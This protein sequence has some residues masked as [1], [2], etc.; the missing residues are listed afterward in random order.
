M[1]DAAAC[2]LAVNAPWLVT[3]RYLALSGFPWMLLCLAALCAADALPA[4]MRQ[5]GVAWHQVASL[6]LC[7]DVL[8]TACHRAAHTWLRGTVVG[9]S[10]A[11]HHTHVRPTPQDAFH[12]GLV[13]ATFQ[14][15][16][17]LVAA[18]HL[19]QP[20]RHSAIA[21]G[22][23]YSWW[24]LFLHSSPDVDYPRLRRLRLVT[25]KLH[26]AHHRDPTV[27]FASVLRPLG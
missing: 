7:V 3:F 26:H 16:A 25:P 12:T 17:P 4:S 21:F 24:L 10:H 1:W 15:V 18:L 19:V 23:A 13:D 6:T 11:V 8:Q 27:H 2:I 20:L 22:C 14:L 9:R 5:P